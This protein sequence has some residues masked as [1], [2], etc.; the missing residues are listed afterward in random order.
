MR[1]PYHA[2]CRDIYIKTILTV[3]NST[4]GCIFGSKYTIA[5]ERLA[6]TETAQI[7]VRVLYLPGT[8]IFL[9][10]DDRDVSEKL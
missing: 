5:E 8:V 10:R 7:V 9:V 3:S 6:A 1:A 4:G 2:G